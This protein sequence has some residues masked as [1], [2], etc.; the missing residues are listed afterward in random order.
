MSN[1]LPGGTVVMFNAEWGLG[2]HLPS[3]PVPDAT[4][5][6]ILAAFVARLEGDGGLD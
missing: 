2:G 1:V 5:P 3:T 6:R 4:R